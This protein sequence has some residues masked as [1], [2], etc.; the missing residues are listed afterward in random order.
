VD[1]QNVADIDIAL[2]NLNLHHPALP[3]VR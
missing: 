2:G 3:P 1:A